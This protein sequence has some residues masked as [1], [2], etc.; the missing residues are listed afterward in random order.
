NLLGPLSSPAG[1]RR[2]LLCVFSP[3][4]LVPLAEVMRDLG[5]EFVWVVHGDG[6]DEI[7]TTGI[8]G[9]AENL[10]KGC[11]I[12]DTVTAPDI[13]EHARAD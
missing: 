1:V 10:A 13:G 9:A 11:G 2:Q 12:G 3:Q 4:W 8:L 6:L 5:S 7:T